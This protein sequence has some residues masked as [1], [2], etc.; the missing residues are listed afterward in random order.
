VLTKKKHLFISV[1]GGESDSGT[2]KVTVN[3]DRGQE[4]PI[5]YDDA[6]VSTSLFMKPVDGFATNYNH[7]H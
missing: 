7:I 1:L 5:S 4:M 3:F 6:F 2:K